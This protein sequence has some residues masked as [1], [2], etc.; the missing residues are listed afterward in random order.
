MRFSL[1]KIKSQVSVFVII[2][3]VIILGIGI[4]YFL[5]SDLNK[6]RI[7]PVVTP[8]YNFVDSC[9]KK[10][11]EDSVY[12]I[13]QTGGYFI[14]PN[15]STENNIAYYFYNEENLI[16]TK[17]K[18]EEELSNYLDNMLFFCTKN[19]E[20]FRDFNVTQGKIKSKTKI[21]KD[22]VLFDVD[23]PL[24]IEKN[25]K[26]YLFEKFE[27][28]VPVRLGVIYDVAKQIM[29]EQMNDKKGICVNCLSEIA[30]KNDVFIYMYDYKKNEILF[31]IA[32]EK[33]KS[34][35]DEFDFYFV[36]KYNPEGINF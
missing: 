22:Y 19:F 36:N 34:R 27:T 10:T 30:E 25:G 18:I 21:E 35:G 12:F 3:V 15:L 7:D 24:N 28:K 1:R 14:T 20:D 33:S 9:I 13:G 5:K 26:T 11:S 2:A 23:Y 4:F 8:L 6:K 16:P 29:E 31:V 17:E 32:D